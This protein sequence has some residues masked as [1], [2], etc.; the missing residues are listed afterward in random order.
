MVASGWGLRSAENRGQNGSA[1]KTRQPVKPV[2]LNCARGGNVVARHDY[3]PFG[4]ELTPS[5]SVPLRTE[6]GRN[7][8]RISL[9]E[10]HRETIE[11]V[12]KVRSEVAGCSNPSL[13]RS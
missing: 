2:R 11:R 9:S 1:G 7:V 6:S 4:E 13:A 5:V 12:Q 8:F 3:L 10:M